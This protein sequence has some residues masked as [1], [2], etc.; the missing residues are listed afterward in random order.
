MTKA[1][2]RIAEPALADLESIQAWYAQQSVPERSTG[3]IGASP[4]VRTG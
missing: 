2:I 3:K 1:A 4:S